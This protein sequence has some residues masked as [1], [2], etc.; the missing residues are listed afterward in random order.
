MSTLDPNRWT[1][2][3]DFLHR[4]GDFAHTPI[5]EATRDGLIGLVYVGSRTAAIPFGR[6]RKATRPMLVL[7]SDDDDTP[8]GPGAW[9]CAEQVTRWARGAIVHGAGMKRWHYDEAVAGALACGRLLMV[10]TASRHV[11]AW[12]ALLPHCRTMLIV[13]R[14]GEHPS[15]PKRGTVH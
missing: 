14:G 15:A 5:F 12:R 4:A 1:L 13:P 9:R 6:I 2:A 8:T 3:I 10:E 11:A 7:V